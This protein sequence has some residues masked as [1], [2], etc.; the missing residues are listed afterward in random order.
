MNQIVWGVLAGLG[1]ATFQGASYFFSRRYVTRPGRGPARLLVHAHL[2]MG[3]AS[4]VLAAI[5]WRS[6]V[7]AFATFTP[8]LLSTSGFYMAGQFL[9]FFVLRH[10]EASRVSPLLGL[11]I[12]ILATISSLFLHTVFDWPQWLAVVLATVAAFLLNYSGKPLAVAPAL[13]ILGACLCYCLSDLSIRAL[14]DALCTDGL[15]RGHASVLGT[16]MS[17][18]LCGGVAVLLIPLWAS[19]HKEDWLAA[20]PF[21]ASWYVGIL[22][23][24][25]AFALAG[26]VLG[27]ILQSTRGILA[28]GIGALLARG[29]G[30]GEGIEPAMSAR[31]WT[32]RIV[33]GLLMTAAVILFI[34]GG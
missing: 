8:A 32:R 26:V 20:V 22:C 25:L 10:T 11:K 23:L 5:F 16:A 28:I 17:Y 27:S 33:A 34:L 4:L 29:K 2:I 18:V 30:K 3:L 21:A 24:F 31:H 19:R 14:V 13:G 12:L 6:E 1:A 9:L 7:P 15:S